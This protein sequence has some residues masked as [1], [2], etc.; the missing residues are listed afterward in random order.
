MPKHP[1]LRPEEGE[2]IPTFVDNASSRSYGGGTDTVGCNSLTGFLWLHSGLGDSAEDEYVEA[3]LASVVA[4]AVAAEAT[5]GITRGG[6]PPIVSTAGGRSTFEFPPT[7]FE[8][9]PTFGGV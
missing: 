8:F 4:L 3:S 1:S 5:T 7:G 9:P 6:Q 2:P